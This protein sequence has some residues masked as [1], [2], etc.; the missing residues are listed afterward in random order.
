MAVWAILVDSSI[1]LRLLLPEVRSHL[2]LNHFYTTN[3]AGIFDWGFF[4]GLFS[5]FARRPPFGNGFPG[6]VQFLAALCLRSLGIIFDPRKDFTFHG[7][8][9]VHQL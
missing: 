9:I 6:Y 1:E 4:F 7:L 3:R 5:L 2:G 8:R